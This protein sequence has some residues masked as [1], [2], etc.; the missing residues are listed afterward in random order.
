MT[1][2]TEKQIAYILSLCDGRHE[3]DAY[4]AIAE[5]MR[6]S[7]SAASKRAT[8]KDASETIDRLRRAA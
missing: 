2:P 1:R 6:V 4:R 5:T 3:S 7:M 8:S